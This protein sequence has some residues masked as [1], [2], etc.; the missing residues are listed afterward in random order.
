MLNILP[1]KFKEE[2]FFRVPGR[3][4]SMQEAS[5]EEQDRAYFALSAQLQKQ[6]DMTIQRASVGGGL[7]GGAG[8][9]VLPEEPSTGNEA[10]IATG[11]G[12]QED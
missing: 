11:T 7:A 1:Q 6:V 2:D 5:Q 4:H 3:Q 8:A 12:D 9:Y 10:L